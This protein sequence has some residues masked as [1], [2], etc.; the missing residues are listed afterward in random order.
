MPDPGLVAEGSVKALLYASVL[1][2][3]GASAVHWLLLPRASTELGADCAA[4]LDLSVARLGLAGVSIAAFSTLLRVWSH[5]VA[6]FGVGDSGILD[7]VAMVALRSHW[8]ESWRI[9]MAAAAVCILTGFVALQHRRF[10]PLYTL[11]T[12]GFAASL[13]MLGHAA[14]SVLR[15][16]VDVAHILAG[17]VWLGSLAVVVLTTIGRPQQIRVA[18]LLRFSAVALPGAGIVVAAGLIAAWLYLGKV[19]DLWLTDYGRVLAL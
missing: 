13:P 10:R 8:G 17:G 15:M 5:T 14:G 2:T 19:S 1:V 6:A 12:V 16:A 3:I 9:Q 4:K 7:N 11:A 18:I